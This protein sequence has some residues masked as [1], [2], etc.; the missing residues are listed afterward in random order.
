[1]GNFAHAATRSPEVEGGAATRL[2]PRP[3]EPRAS[4][5]SPD[6]P[7]TIMPV[8]SGSRVTSSFL[9]VV[10]QAGPDVRFQMNTPD[11]S[12]SLSGPFLWYSLLGSTGVGQEGGTW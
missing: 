8:S 1:M 3:R 5:A 11:Y 4:A 6:A 12:C 2:E 9:T 7:A 10:C